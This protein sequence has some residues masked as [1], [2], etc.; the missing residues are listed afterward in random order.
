MKQFVALTDKAL[1]AENS[2][3]VGAWEPI[4]SELFAGRSGHNTYVYSLDRPELERLIKSGHGIAYSSE[5]I[6]VFNSR[7]AGVDLALFGARNVRQMLVGQ[8]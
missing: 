2:V 3:V 1:P 6:R 5:V 8:P 7:A 4:I